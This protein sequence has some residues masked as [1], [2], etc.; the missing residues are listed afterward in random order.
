MD[1]EVNYLPSINSVRYTQRIIQTV[2]S[3]Q[4]DIFS[5]AD[6]FSHYTGSYDVK[7][8]M[9]SKLHERNDDDGLFQGKDGERPGIDHDCG[10]NVRLLRGRAQFASLRCRPLFY[11]RPPPIPRQWDSQELPMPTYEDDYDREAMLGHGG[12]RASDQAMSDR[13]V[14]HDDRREHRQE[15]GQAPRGSHSV[16]R[17]ER[18]PST[19][20]PARHACV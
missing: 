1:R 16:F 7:T 20:S 5:R 15:Y 6:T 17:S 3:R 8:H 19:Y 10:G 4:A 18:T 12:H 14:L 9:K 11:P 13:P 2:K